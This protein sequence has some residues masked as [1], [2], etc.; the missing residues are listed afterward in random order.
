MTIIEVLIWIGIMLLGFAGSALYSGLE[1]GSYQLNRIRLQVARDRSLPGAATLDRLVHKPATLLSVLLI[2][3]NLANYMGTAAVTRF[4]EASGLGQWAQIAINTAVLTPLL[5]IFGEILPKDLFARH[6]D[7]L[8]YRFAKGLEVSR[9]LFTWTGLV[10]VVQGVGNLGIRLF[11]Q[12]DSVDMT[13]PRRRFGALVKEGAGYGV[14]SLEQTA[15]TD[16]VLAMSSRKVAQEVVPWRSV[17]TVRVEDPLQRLREL[18][19]R[20]G[21]SRYPVMEAGQV[22]GVVHLM[23]ALAPRNS[24]PEGPETIRSIM[25]PAT[26]I[27]PKT[28]VRQGLATMQQRHVG[29]AI[30]GDESGLPMGIVTVKDLVETITGELTAW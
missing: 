24:K 21:R 11:G 3:N 19:H 14:L 4:F 30:V 8:M 1:T 2:G 23:D 22:V 16:R 25:K 27:D 12:Q 9:W 28:T 6:A 17:H 7:R 29:L 15:L 10:P 13:H 26:R 20:T 5:L 18:G